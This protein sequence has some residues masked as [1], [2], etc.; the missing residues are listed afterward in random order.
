MDETAHK[1]EAQI[2]WSRE[3][4]GSNLRELED[5]VAAATDWREQFRERPQLFLGAA[6]IGGVVIAGALRPKS[7]G[8]AI[9]ALSTHPPGDG[10]G[11]LQAQAS[12]LWH[13]VQEALLGVASVRIKEY[14]GELLPGFDE[15]YRRAEQRTNMVDPSTG[16]LG[17]ATTG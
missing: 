5:R 3:R 11:S 9:A 2:D 1:I 7:A 17:R 13:N 14:I 12:Q 8:R 16:S 6:F 10:G 15:H 4:L